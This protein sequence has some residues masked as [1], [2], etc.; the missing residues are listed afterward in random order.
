MVKKILVFSD[1]HLRPLELESGSK[2]LGQLTH[3]IRETQPSA[4]VFCGDL[5]HTKSIMYASATKCFSDYL[6]S[7]NREGLINPDRKMYLIIGNHDYATLHTVHSLEQFK[8]HQN[9]I[10]VEEATRISDKI[11]LV[12]YCHDQSR[13]DSE[14]DKLPGCDMIFGHFD[15]NTFEL[16]AGYEERHAYLSPG[17]FSNRGYRLVVSGHLHVPQD[18]NYGSMQITYVGS[19]YTVDW[20]ESD[21]QKRFL[22]VDTDTY[23]TSSIPTHLTLHKTITVSTRDKLPELPASELAAG[24]H[25]RVKVTGTMEEHAVW[26]K[27]SK[28]QA[29]VV[30]VVEGSKSSRLDVSVSEDPDS[31]LE[32]YTAMELAKGALLPEA[33]SFYEKVQSTDVDISVQRFE[34][35]LLEHGKRLVARA[36]AQG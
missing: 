11:G 7:L 15:I 27:P 6:D 36:K 19:P 18:K 4:V 14:L 3:T 1:L 32:R 2:A 30:P 35:A 12:S 5:F 21:Q 24:I 9:V 23:E 8:K 26:E 29:L 22:M 33:R 28:Y 16:T 20:G 31:I 17:Y 10:V 13:L 25:F 34:K